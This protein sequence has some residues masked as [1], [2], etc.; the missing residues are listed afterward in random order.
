MG[1]VIHAPG[2]VHTINVDVAIASV[3]SVEA[4]SAGSSIRD[5][6]ASAIAAADKVRDYPNCPV[7]S[8]AVE[9]HDRLG[10]D[11][12][13]LVRMLAPTDA[14]DRS[15]AIREAASEYRS[16]VAEARSGSSGCSRM[17]TR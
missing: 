11:A 4:Q 9:D 8:S 6:A 13:Q 16:G 15:I 1:T 14:T 10:G 3:S 17:P 7:M 5:G 12:I 2:V